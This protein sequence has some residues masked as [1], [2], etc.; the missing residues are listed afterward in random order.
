MKTIFTASTALIAAGI[1]PTALMATMPPPN[2]LAR[3]QRTQHE[4]VAFSGVH[5]IKLKLAFA[6][7]HVVS[8]SS[9]K[10]EFDVVRSAKKPVADSVRKWLD[11]GD[12]VVTNGGSAITIEDSPLRAHQLDKGH[13]TD[14]SAGREEV[15]LHIPSGLDLETSLGAGRIETKGRY[16]SVT[17]NLGAGEYVAHLDSGP[18]GGSSIHVGAGEVK[19]ELSSHVDATV[20]ASVGV[21]KISGLPKS[22]DKGPGMGDRRSGVLGNGGTSLGIHVGAG[23][24]SVITSQSVRAQSISDDSRGAAQRF[25][26]DSDEDHDSQDRDDHEFRD[27]DKVGDEVDRALK[28]A[29]PEIDRAMRE[30]RPEID[31][32]MERV[33]P[34]I[35]RA[36]AQIQPEIERAM[37][38]AKPEIE[39]AKREHRK[40]FDLEIKKIRPEMSREI[41]HAMAEMEK[42]EAEVNSKEMRDL[43]QHG[44]LREI[45]REAMRAA[46]EAMKKAI[47]SS[48]HMLD[49]MSD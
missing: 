3:E 4:S 37:R 33:G 14:D 39:R 12:L 31:R 16:R 25:D 15:T 32:A 42:A 45:I 18:T 38:E 30:A 26:S 29:Q 34:E 49:E 13:N 5:R 27:L 41:A 48:R 28:Q 1:I 22:G 44:H 46:R 35:Q 47:E 23:D 7:V 17:S 19:V 43:D 9:S 40:E 6:Q 21:G 10:L 8:D 36:M 20:A 24:I 2:Q 11:N